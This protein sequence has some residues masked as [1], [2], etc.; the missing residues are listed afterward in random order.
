MDHNKW[1]SI[2]TPIIPICKVEYELH[3]SID[4][5]MS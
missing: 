5:I 1:N 4:V 2:K 3:R